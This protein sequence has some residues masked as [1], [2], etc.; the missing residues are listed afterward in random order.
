MRG[1]N[2]FTVMKISYQENTGTRNPAHSYSKFCIRAK[3]TARLKLGVKALNRAFAGNN[4]C[5]LGEFFPFGVC[6]AITSNNSNQHLQ[7]T[8]LTMNAQVFE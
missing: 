4:S 2:Q 8:W 7:K 3:P 6:T 1:K 5:N